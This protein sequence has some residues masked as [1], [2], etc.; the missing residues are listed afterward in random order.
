MQNNERER[1][2]EALESMKFSYNDKFKGASKRNKK[3]KI[4]EKIID[5]HGYTSSRSEE[6][7]ETALRSN[8][9][10]S[11]TQI[12][13]ICGRGIHSEGKPVLKKSVEEVLMRMKKHYEKY[14]V[15]IN[16]NF[17]IIMKEKR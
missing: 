17:T 14:F 10:S 1:F 15:D 5:L 12:K 2:K 11:V 6:I 7:V 4:K 8:I 9:N 13:I 3:K 16:N